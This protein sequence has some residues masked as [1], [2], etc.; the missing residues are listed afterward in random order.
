MDICL[1]N[2]AGS[3]AGFRYEIEAR[4]NPG[5]ANGSDGFQAPTAPRMHP[6]SGRA[7]IVHRFDR[8]MFKLIDEL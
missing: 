6:E 1:L 2:R 5:N 8:W 3:I 4:G 7:K